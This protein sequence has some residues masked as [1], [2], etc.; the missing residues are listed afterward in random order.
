[1]ERG[2][3][4][5]DLVVVGAAQVFYKLAGYVILAMLARHLPKDRFGAF[6]FAASVAA[7]FVL[8]TDFGTRDHLLREAAAYPGRAARELAGVLGLRLALFGIYA[9]A[10]VVFALFFKP[11]VL[12][13]LLLSALYVGLRDLYRTF[14]ATFLALRKVSPHVLLFG[15]GEL[16]LV[17]LVALVVLSGRG[18]Y[19]VLGAYTV[20]AACLVSAGAVYAWREVGLGP[21]RLDRGTGARLIRSSAPFFA[22]TVLA[23]VHFKV[24]T[25]MLGFLRPY[26]DVANYE[27]SAKLLEASQFVV[28]P[29][30]AIYLPVCVGLAAAGEWAPLRRKGRR[31]LGAGA[32][33][34]VLVAVAVV[35]VAGGVVPM[36]YGSGFDEAV[37]LLRVLY[38]SVPALYVGLVATFLASALHVE[39]RGVLILLAG[40]L[41]NVGLNALL[42][43]PWGSM[44]AAVTTVISQVCVSVGLGGLCLRVLARRARQGAEPGGEAPERDDRLPAP[45]GPV[46]EGEWLAPLPGGEAR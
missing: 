19:G 3:V 28:R 4:R 20:A 40:V 45:E 30:A 46:P 43:P 25:L 41:L 36:V 10:V 22:L 7:L 12:A 14:G 29:A 15:G 8:L 38:L 16:L 39:K 44:G 17:G 18:L 37:P 33:V 9:S 13:V 26:T 35:A 42:I 32:G 24:D 11:D 34:G 27:A 31:L 1:M 5:R 21:P 23:L 6:L 2:R